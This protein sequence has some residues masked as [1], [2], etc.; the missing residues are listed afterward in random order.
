MQH[1]LFCLYCFIFM[2]VTQFIHEF[3]V[4]KFI[5][6]F[7]TKTIQCIIFVNNYIKFKVAV[8]TFL[9]ISNK[10]CFYSFISKIKTKLVK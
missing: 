4:V 9:S 7:S 10:L 1:I 3:K 6:D 2:K 8:I 5:I